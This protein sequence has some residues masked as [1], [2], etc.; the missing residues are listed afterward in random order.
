METQIAIYFESFLR[1]VLRIEL[2]GFWIDVTNISQK[3]V[4]FITHLTEYIR[5]RDVLVTT[6]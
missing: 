3:S 2:I 1:I 5:V 6:K 4:G